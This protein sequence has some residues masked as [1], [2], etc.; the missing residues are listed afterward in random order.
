M[1][2]NGLAVDTGRGLS[3]SSSVVVVAIVAMTAIG[4]AKMGQ[5]KAMKAFKEAN[6]AYAQQ[7]YKKAADLYEQTVQA[8]AS[9]LPAAYFYLG[10]SYDNL[11]KPSKKGD[12]T[13]DDLLNKAV[14]NYQQAAEKLAA[15]A[16]PEDKK[17]GKLSMEYLVAAYG[18]DKLNDPAKAEPVVQRM[19][20]ARPGRSRP[21][22]SRS[23]RSTKTRARTKTRKTSC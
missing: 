20:H 17:L 4:C 2:R 1:P 16:K 6:Q 19:I 11:Y 5:L 21:T 15:S 12:A 3:G 7:D 22:T 18:P 10:N 13:N 23:P 14:Q 8:D 9:S